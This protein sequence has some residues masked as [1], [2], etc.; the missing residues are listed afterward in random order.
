M[1]IFSFF[2]NCNEHCRSIIYKAPRRDKRRER[3]R[4]KKRHLLNWITVERNLQREEINPII[5]TLKTRELV[6]LFFQSYSCCYYWGRRGRAAIVGM[7]D[8]HEFK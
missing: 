3:E 6:V 8:L 1:D 4:E 7:E 5:S 2:L